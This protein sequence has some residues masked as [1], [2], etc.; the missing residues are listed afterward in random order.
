MDMKK[1]ERIRKQLRVPAE[2]VKE[3]DDYAKKY[4]MT[5]SAAMFQLA[6]KGLESEQKATTDK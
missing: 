3:I 1:D 2:L 6:W 5:F 4:S